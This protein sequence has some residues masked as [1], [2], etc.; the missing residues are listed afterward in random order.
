MEFLL[1]YGLFLAKVLTFAAVV[2]VVL[3]LAKSAGGRQGHKGELEITNLTEKHKDLVHSMESHLYDEAA[4]K[5]RDKADKKAEKA[6][7]K[8]AKAEAKKVTDSEALAAGR[9]PHLFVLDFKGS[10][11]AREV[12]SLR[13]EVT[14]ILA[15]AK[16]GDEVMIRLES[17]GGMVHAYGL[18]SSQLAR[19]KQAGIPLTVSVD[20]VA[21]SGGYMMACVA[22]KIIAAPF[23]VV[24]SIG[25]I[26]SCLTSI[27]SLKNMILN[28]NS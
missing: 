19:I 15:V 10:I 26:A 14:A 3:I 4:L 22:D 8:E 23:A 20:K 5:A 18:A 1:D 25:V 9:K 12:A 7:A 13:E 28:L 17:G 16:D 27:N 2:I 6:K 24:G 11:D 21:A